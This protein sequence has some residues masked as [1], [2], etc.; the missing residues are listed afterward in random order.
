LTAERWTL[1]AALGIG[2]R[3]ELVAFVGGGGKTGLMFALAAEL[4]GRVVITTTTRIFAAQMSKAPAVVYADDLAPLRGALDEHGRC[5][6]VGRV[7]GEKALGVDP[8]LP[9]RLLARPDVDW[10]LV[11]ADGS[12]MRPVKAPAAHEPVVPAE[13]TLLVPVA[14]ID[15]LAGPLEEVAHRPELV[16]ELLRRRT[17]YDLE[18]IPVARPLTEDGRLTPAGLARLITHPAGGLKSAPTR[19]RIIPFLNKVETEEQL[20]A[21]RE[22]ASMML[23]EPRVSRAVIGALHDEEPVREVWRRITAV[24]LAAGESSRMGRNKLLLPWGNTTVLGRTLANVRA[25]AIRELIIVIGYERERIE[26]EGAKEVE[27]LP[28]IFNKDY[29]KGMLSSVQAA[30]QG[31]PLETEA[32]LVVLGDQPMVEALVINALLRDYAAGPWG[33]VAPTHRGA[34]GN[35]VLIDRRYFTE[36]LALPPGAAPRALLQ[37]HADDLRLVEVDSDAI[38]LDLDRPEE[39]DRR[40]PKE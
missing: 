40:R 10:V 11:E 23:D 29:A 1:R 16:R 35:P 15:A 22:A 39:Y 30:V 4:P 6:V 31:L 34:R 36:L 19:A 12:R 18:T 38:L 3:P 7:K 26:S 27:G 8:D 21:A 14:G 33:L 24:V 9:A 28:I 2:E 17:I 13:T 25:A 37:R 20:S 32:I 5:L